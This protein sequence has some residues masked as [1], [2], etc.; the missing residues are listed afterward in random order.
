M[1]NLVLENV[2]QSTLKELGLDLNI[3][4]GKGYDG[5]TTMSGN[6]HVAQA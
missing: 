2:I 6:F 3:L 1:I 5:A 4:R